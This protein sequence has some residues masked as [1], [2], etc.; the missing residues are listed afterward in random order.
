MQTALPALRE[1]GWLIEFDEEF[2]HHALQV[3]AWEADLVPSENGWFDLDMGVIVDGERLPLAPLLASLFKRDARWLETVE[4]LKIDDDEPIE[5]RTPRNL[6]LR[7]PAGRLKPIATTLIDLFDSFD[8]GRLKI[9]RFDAQRLK[10]LS[11]T[12]RWQF[13]GQ[14]EIV[15][16]ADRLMAAQ[17]V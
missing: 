16:L 17:G 13:R 5:L 11:D 4:L 15:A 3:D 7:V 10:V 14:E 6:R 12:S 9:S 8:G 2:R 1:A